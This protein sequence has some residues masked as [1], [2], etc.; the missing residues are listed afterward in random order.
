MVE[1]SWNLLIEPHSLVAQ[2]YKSRYFPDSDFQSA[3]LGT[4]PSFIWRSIMATHDFLTS[5]IGIRLGTGVNINIWNHA[6]I[7]DSLNPYVETNPVSYLQHVDSLIVNKQWN[8][9]LITDVFSVR[10]RDLILSLPISKFDIEDKIYWRWGKLGQFSVKSA[11]HRL[12]VINNC[13]TMPCITN[14]KWLWAMSI[15]PKIKNFIWRSLSFCLPTLCNLSDRMPDV[16]VTC[17]L[18]TLHSEDDIHALVNCPAVQQVWRYSRFKFDFVSDITFT[19]WWNSKVCSLSKSDMEEIAMVLW[20]IWSNRNKKVWNNKIDSAFSIIQRATTQLTQWRNIQVVNSLQSG[21]KKK[22]ELQRWQKPTGTHLKC[23]VDASV[24]DSHCGY[25][26]VLRDSNGVVLPAIRGRFQGIYSPR[27]AEALSIREVLSWLKTN[28]REDVIVESDA[29]CIV[30]AIN[31][32]NA[33]F[34]HFGAVI[35]DCKTLVNSLING[36]VSWVGRSANNLA[37][38]LA[39]VDCFMPDRESWDLSMPLNISAVVLADLY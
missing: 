16:D 31:S 25:A 15:P 12:M 2:I 32:N 7:P 23:N 11:Y 22:T 26:G 17:P 8:I 20:Q 21:I 4:N 36:V 38:T 10:D 5:N 37:H 39:R 1:Q 33:D 30:Q 6:W 3:S 27:L 35:E 18:C 24:T 28:G 9:S 19:A 34:S 14:W 29:L 13:N